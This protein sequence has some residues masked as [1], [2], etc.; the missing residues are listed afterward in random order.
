[1]SD[2]IRIATAVD[3]P[4]LHRLLQA[5]YQ[6][7]REMNIRFTAATADVDLV[8][9]KI[10]RHTTFVV[11]RDATIIA[12]VSVRFPWPMGEN[13]LTSY[14]FLHWFAVAPELKRQSIGSALLDHVELDFL[15]DQIKAPAVYLATATRHP[16]LM[17]I[18]ERRGYEGF[19]KRNKDGD[20]MVLLRK[21]LNPRIYETL[22]VAEYERFEPHLAQAQ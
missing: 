2:S 13:H 19:Y 22:E 5:A 20:E 16:W 17:G 3:A 10:D 8:R 4:D 11:E 1:M 9:E 14:P 12:T 6:P 21:I 7:L 15:R 18:Y